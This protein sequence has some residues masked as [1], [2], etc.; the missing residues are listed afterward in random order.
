MT[1]V[2]VVGVTASCFVKWPVATLLTFCVMIVS[3]WGRTML[4]GAIKSFLDKDVESVGATEALY[5]LLTHMNMQS[6]MPD[7]TLSVVIE[8]FDLIVFDLFLG[9]YL[10]RNLRE[11]YIAIVYFPILFA[12]FVGGVLKGYKKLISG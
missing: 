1:M 8:Q 11:V 12:Y 2:I 9:A 7:T 5:R 3:V 6:P 10:A 4:D